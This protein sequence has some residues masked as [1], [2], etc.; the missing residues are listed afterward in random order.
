MVS[1]YV[2]AQYITPQA[3][4]TS[5]FFAAPEGDYESHDQD[6]YRHHGD[7]DCRAAGIDQTG[8]RA[9]GAAAGLIISGI[10]AG[11]VVAAAINCR[12]L[13]VFALQVIHYV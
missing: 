1:P 9:A 5:A 12:Y 4:A 10:I 7:G 11:A 3:K 8:R 2:C 6:D 13:P